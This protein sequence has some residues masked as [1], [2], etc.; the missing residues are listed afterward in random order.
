M[1][2]RY[3]ARLGL[4]I[5]ACDRAFAAAVRSAA[6]DRASVGFS[7]GPAPVRKRVQLGVGAE[8]RLGDWVRIP[9]TWKARPATPLFPV[10]GG[11]LQLEPATADE[12]RLSLKATYQ[13]PLGRLG[14]AIDNAAMHRIARATVKDFVDSV[15]TRLHNSAIADSS[16]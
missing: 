8:E 15:R 3:S 9:I 16:P 14:A 10:L 4:P 1:Y 11:Y 2:I 6:G 13:P 5:A 7:V 12:S